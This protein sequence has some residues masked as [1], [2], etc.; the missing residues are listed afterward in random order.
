M[1]ASSSYQETCYRLDAKSDLRDRVLGKVEKD[2][3]IA[4]PGKGGH[5]GLLPW[6]TMCPN[7]GGFDEE[8]YSNGLRVGLLIRLGCV[9]GLQAFTLVS[10][11][12][13]PNLDELLW[14]L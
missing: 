2:S 4:L 5:N 7:L 8:F 11:G 9:Q 1:P 6:K 12:R 10:G 13:S 3:F 14:S